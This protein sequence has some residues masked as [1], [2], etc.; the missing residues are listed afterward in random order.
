[1]PGATE[2]HI[3]HKLCRRFLG[4]ARVRVIHRRP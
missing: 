4:A 1:V 2:G 3:Q